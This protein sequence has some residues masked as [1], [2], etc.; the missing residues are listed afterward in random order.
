MIAVFSIIVGAPAV[1]AFEVPETVTIPAGSFIEGS[2]RAER[3]YGYK[4]DEAAYGH[5]RTRQWKWYER[6]R[7][8]AEVYL[9]VFEISRTLVTNRLYE[10]FV[11]ETGH[12]VPDASRTLWDSYGLIH[13]YQRMLRHAWKGGVIPHGREDHPVVMVS[14]DDATAFTAWLS[15]K[16]GD[17]WRLP[18]QQEWEKAARGTDG[19][20]FPWGDAFDETRLNSHDAGPFDTM[21]V[22]R[23]PDGN[24]PYGV[25]DM[26][27]QVFE[28]TGDVADNGKVWVKGGGSW[29]DRGCGICRAAARHARPADLKHILIGFHLVREPGK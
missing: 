22:A 14:H 7:K 15:E 9:P 16:T 8:R 17:T 10:A 29:D 5:S 23:F 11:T 1:Y 2:D 21:P 28:W 3:E 24:S 18:T 20:Y 19:R 27:G 26:A 4:L 12:R 13:P 6:D 25:T